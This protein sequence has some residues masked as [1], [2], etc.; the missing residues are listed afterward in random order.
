[1]VSRTYVLLLLLGLWAGA[2]AQQ[3]ARAPNPASRA[4]VPDAAPAVAPQMPQPGPIVLT[5][6]AIL[7]LL[8]LSPEQQQRVRDIR[9]RYAQQLLDMRQSVEERRDALREAIYGETLDPQRVEQLLREFL[10]RQAAL[11]RLE[12]QLELE[13]RQVLTPEQ[14]AK[15][16]QIQSEELAIRR[17]R[18]ELRQREERLRQ[19]LRGG[20]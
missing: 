2:R 13:F 5:R 8:N 15:F 7:R 12:T 3:G 4:N 9:R 20:S 14:L 6:L 18:R 16:R 10:E 17:M 19:R 1:M 11:V